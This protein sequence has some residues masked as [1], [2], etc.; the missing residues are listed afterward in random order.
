MASW[1]SPSSTTL[2]S[3]RGARRVARWQRAARAPAAESNRALALAAVPPPFLRHRR[4]SSEWLEFRVGVRCA[5]CGVRCAV[6][7]VRCAMCCVRCAVCGVWWSEGCGVWVLC[8]GSGVWCLVCG[9]CPHL[10]Q[11][12]RVQGSGF[13]VHCSGF[14]AAGRRECPGR[15][16]A[17]KRFASLRL[18]G[19][20]LQGKL[21][22]QHPC[23]GFRV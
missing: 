5:V 21:R 16:H 20:P 7:G 14:R 17:V 12:F 22:Q 18:L 23:S 15:L 11:R 3:L 13:R 10:E 9:V 4:P 6:C 19:C 1:V 2:A 8:V